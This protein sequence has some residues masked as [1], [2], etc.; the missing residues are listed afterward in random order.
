[1]CGK[2]P[3]WLTDVPRSLPSCRVTNALMLFLFNSCFLLH[4][5]ISSYQN[6]QPIESVLWP[7]GLW[8]KFSL[9]VFLPLK[10]GTSLFWT[11]DFQ[12]T[13]LVG[14]HSVHITHHS[15]EEFR[16]IVTWMV[17][18]VRNWIFLTP[19]K[20]WLWRINILASFFGEQS[21]QFP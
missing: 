6:I 4:F 13:H 7:Y 1:M 18:A 12:Q 8:P 15:L 16:G 21:H 11:S 3:S 2:F 20:E 5:F 19:S 9:N 14:K 17:E 10:E